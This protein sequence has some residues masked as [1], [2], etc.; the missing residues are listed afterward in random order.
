ML[1]LNPKPL[2]PKPN[3]LRP[4]DCHLRFRVQGFDSGYM[5]WVVARNPPYALTPNLI[6]PLAKE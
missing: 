6:F 4:S 3:P 2:D 5:G 1:E